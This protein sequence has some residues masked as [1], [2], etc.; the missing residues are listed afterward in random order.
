MN[1]LGW[2]LVHFLWQGA[3]IG[4]FLAA[5]L[6]ATR[7]YTAKV[8]YALACGAL[9]A[10]ALCVPATTAFLW[11]SASSPVQLVQMDGGRL[12]LQAAVLH[13]PGL[14]EQAQLSV[15]GAIPWLVGI[16]MTG[17]VLLLA[18]ASGGWSLARRRV[19]AGVYLE[20]DWS[21]L[22]NR[23][24][25]PRAFEVL[26]SPLVHV[27][28]VF[29]WLKPVV[30]LP[31]SA[32]TG[33]PP[34]QLEAIV[35]H[36][37]AH[38][39]RN[40]YLVNLLQTLTESVLFYHPAVW[41]ASERIREERESCCDDAVVE[42]T[43]DSVMYSRALL[44][45]E[46]TRMTI[47]PAATSSGLG[48]RI[49][50][51]LG[52]QRE[53][54]YSAPAAIAVAAMMVIGGLTWLN[55]AP[56][57][58][59]EPPSTPVV[60]SLQAP[61]PPPAPAPPPAPR[62]SKAPKAAIAP[63]PPPPP[64]APPPAPPPPPPP[65]DEDGDDWPM[66]KAEWKKMQLE[67]QRE[68]ALVQEEMKKVNTEEMKRAMEDA[69]KELEKVREHLNSKEFQEEIR[70]AAEIGMK[71]AQKAMQEAQFAMQK[72][73]EEMAAANL[74]RA[75]R[76]RKADEKWSV[77]DIP[78]STTPRGRIYVRNGPPD[79]IEVVNGVETWRYQDPAKKDP[80]RDYKFDAK[81]ERVK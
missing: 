31:A 9:T 52:K 21:E 81:G 10:M 70:K 63:V 43:G 14:L 4:A 46:E 28:H 20:R 79:Q 55:A 7:D 58:P 30:M 25:V 61:P 62:S 75:R 8:R 51:M 39:A 34:D 40:D 36:E 18:R 12:R 1:A 71:E 73:H 5:A 56:P 19:R 17:V 69:R 15:N 72:A 29:G 23:L 47:V 67:L 3:A 74:E 24:G 49:S 6:W 26:V 54:T 2:A 33:L 13:E 45:L 80:P 11:D 60:A 64:A 22:A 66:S 57:A 27:P 41:W 77:G 37:L 50:R 76:I 35:A 59:P 65:R 42:L 32:V 68:L 53:E 16:W 38:I 44:A 48:E 78:G